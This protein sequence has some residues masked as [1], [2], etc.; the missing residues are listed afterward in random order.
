MSTTDEIKARLDIVNYIQQYVPLKKSGRYYKAPCPFHNERTPSFVVDPDRQ[1]WRCFGACSEG[2]DIFNFAMKHHG[3][4]FTDALNALAEQAGVEVRQRSQEDKARDEHV[5]KLRGL[6]KTIADVYHSHLIEGNTPEAKAVRAYAMDKRGLSLETI[7]KFGIGFAPSG[8]GNALEYLTNLGYSEEEVIEA[9]VALKNDRGNVYDRFRNRLVIPIRDQRGR[10][11]GF[12]GRVLDPE[13]QPKYINSPQS[14]VFDKSRILFGLDLAREMIRKIETAV[15]VEG[16]M[17]AIQAHQ[18]GFMNVVAQMG[19]AMTETQLRLIAPRDAKKIIL[20][21]DADA[22]G[23]NATQRSLETARQTLVADFS[24]K[25][26]V[27]IR[28]L[29]IPNAKDPDDLLREE[30][31]HWQTLVDDALPVADYVINAEVDALPDTASVQEREAA[32]KRVLPI[33]IAS[34]NDLVKQDN[35]QKL[36]LKLRIP[37]RNLLAWSQEKRA[38]IKPVRRESPPPASDDPPPLD[39][40]AL[41]PPPDD[42]LEDGDYIIDMA[43]GHAPIIEPLAESVELHCLRTL[44]ANPELVYAVNRKL[45]ELANDNPA[46]SD[47]PLADLNAYDFTRTEY[48][49]MISVFVDAVNQ[50][51]LDVLDYMQSNLDPVVKGVFKQIMVGDPEH[52]KGRVG[53]RRFNGDFVSIWKKHERRY[54]V[55]TQDEEFIGKT[56]QLR[57]QRL[58]RELDEM[59]FAQRDSQNNNHEPSALELGMRIVLSTQAKTKLE[60]EISTLSARIL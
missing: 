47:G 10:V 38:E 20:A 17:D 37:E 42:D 12:G 50:H 5:D 56:L 26:S 23:Q 39:Y 43:V 57:V 53:E 36:A 7:R 6:L 13:D 51:D 19:T 46:M 31:D 45:R 48:Q 1:S 40:D 52:V 33:L 60:A 16:Y 58:R 54:Y 14:A 49:A 29:Q 22:A 30:P 15:I 27:D 41:E 21:L 2:G 4:D 11:V 24:G 59:S 9:G 34:E 35:I 25:L 55:D 3:W 32:A 28:I 18:A 8:W 44:F